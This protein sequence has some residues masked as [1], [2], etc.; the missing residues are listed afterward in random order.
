M[1]DIGLVNELV[2]GPLDGTVWYSDW[3]PHWS[4]RIAY[5]TRG[6]RGGHRWANYELQTSQLKWTN[7]QASVHFRYQFVGFR[8]TFP[9]RFAW[10]ASKLILGGRWLTA[11]YLGAR[12]YNAQPSRFSQKSSPSQ[13]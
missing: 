3:V 1:N 9:S 10:L 11:S 4:Q 13:K 12:L 8:E 2:G 6:P 5:V 7:A